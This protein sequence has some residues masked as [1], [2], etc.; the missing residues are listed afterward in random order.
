V[1]NIRSTTGRGS[2]Q[3][4]VFFDWQANMVQ[5][6]LHVLSRIAQVKAELPAAASTEVH[7]MTFSEFPI[8][9]VS[10][11]SPT[12]TLA[13]LWEAARYNIKPRLLRI[14]GVA[15]VEI[16]GGRE[17]EYHVVVDPVKLY[18]YV[19]LGRPVITV[20]YPEL[21]RFRGLVTFYDSEAEFL[22]AIRCLRRDPGSM[23]PDPRARP[24]RRRWRGRPPRAALP[25]PT[26]RAN[27]PPRRAATARRTASIGNEVPAR[28]RGQRALDRVAGLL[29]V[30]RDELHLAAPI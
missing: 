10:L 15:R 14:P 28:Q 17:P 6:E 30:L 12:R 22:E 3:V 27:A 2:A 13:D 20:H 19:A 18:E 9:G 5:S 1:V 7:R 24:A 29:E 11:T 4:D 8:I 25:A 23:M 16:V 21:E 26:D